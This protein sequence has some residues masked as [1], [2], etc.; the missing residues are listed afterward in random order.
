MGLETGMSLRNRRD[1][2]GWS[3]VGDVRCPVRVGP[4]PQ[5]LPCLARSWDFVPKSVGKRRQ[6][7]DATYDSAKVA[8][9]VSKAVWG[10]CGVSCYVIQAR[11][12]GGSGADGVGGGGR[13]RA[14][15]RRIRGTLL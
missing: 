11:D 9:A 12:S 14:P 1:Q 10:G 15:L 2:G 13:A 4:G 6:V 7:L 3:L 5:D 8:W